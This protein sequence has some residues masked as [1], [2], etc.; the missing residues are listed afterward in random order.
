MMIVGIY[1]KKK[2]K[3][4]NL[5]LIEKEK[6]GS[7]SIGIDRPNAKLV[8]IIGGKHFIR[9][10]GIDPKYNLRLDEYERL[11]IIN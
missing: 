4:Q 9:W 5:L 6:D 7:L 1:N 8:K 11:K 2:S 3:E 10:Y